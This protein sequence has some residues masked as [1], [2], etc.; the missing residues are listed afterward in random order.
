ME[1]STEAATP[2]NLAEYSVSELA[3][4]L[5]RTLEDALR[6][7]RLRGEI[8]GFRGPHAS[9]HCY[10]ALKDDKATIEAVIWRSTFQRLKFKP[11]AGMEVIATGPH[12]HLSRLVEIPDRH[13]GAG[14]RR[15]RRAD[16]AARGAQEEARRRGPVRRERARSRCPS[17]RASSASSPRR[18]APSSATCCTASPT[19]FPPTFFVWPVGCRARPARAEV[20]AAIRGFNA[21]PT[22]AAS[23]GPTCII[24]ARGGGSLEDL[25]GFNEEIVVRAAAASAHP[26]DLRGRPRDRLDA[27][28]PRRRCARADADSAA[29]RAVP[30]RSDLLITVTQH[31]VRV[32]TS[33]RRRIEVERNRFNGLARGLPR[34]ANILDLPRQRFDTASVRLKRALIANARVH[35]NWLERSAGR[36]NAHVLVRAA[37]NG[38]DKL[39]RLDRAASRAEQALLARSRVRLDAQAETARDAGLPECARARLCAGALR[40][41]RHDP[42]RRRGQGG[43]RSRHRVRRCP[44]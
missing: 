29:E 32:A 30:V 36:L 5:K 9:G 4:A 12:H 28:R 10:F 41:R 16:G 27:H 43:R 14:A 37:R 23:R 7:V 6:L 34:K 39:V 20:A 31:G 8:S 13:R 40:R 26:A 3:S 38:R 18:P 33:L 17:C 35:R 1:Q 2:G 25:W 44:H 11:E 21:L 15:R 22:A 42:P 24:V 19:A